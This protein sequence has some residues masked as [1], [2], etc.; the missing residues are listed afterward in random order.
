M[1]IVANV[2]VAQGLCNGT[3]IQIVECADDIIWCRYIAGPREGQVFPLSRHMFT[4]GGEERINQEGGAERKYL[5]F[6]LRPGFALTINKSQ[7][8]RLRNI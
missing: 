6:P 4:F 3:R 1:M 7:G 5:Q 2:C 8:S